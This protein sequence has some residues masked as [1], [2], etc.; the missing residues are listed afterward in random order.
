[1]KD[2]TKKDRKKE[3]KGRND[4]AFRKNPDGVS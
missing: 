4:V 2:M 1:M 3:K